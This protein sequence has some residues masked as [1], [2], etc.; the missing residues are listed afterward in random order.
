MMYNSQKGKPE[1]SWKMIYFLVKLFWIKN[2]NM[3]KFQR[4]QTKK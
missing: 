3:N 2:Y 4:K 1:I